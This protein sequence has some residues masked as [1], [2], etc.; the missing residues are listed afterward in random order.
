MK[1][2]NPVDLGMQL[3][4]A[5]FTQ[6]G[7]HYEVHLTEVELAALLALAAERALGVRR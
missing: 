1:R 4:R 6:R 2:H 3:A 7:D 5:F